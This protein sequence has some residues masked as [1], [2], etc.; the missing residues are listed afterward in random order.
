MTLLWSRTV[1][2]ECVFVRRAADSFVARNRHT[3]ARHWV[4]RTQELCLCAISLWIAGEMIRAGVPYRA[5][6][7]FHRQIAMHRVIACKI[8]SP[9]CA[10]LA[11]R[12]AAERSARWRRIKKYQKVSRLS[13]TLLPALAFRLVLLLRRPAGSGMLSMQS[14][15]KF[16]YLFNEN[17]AQS[18]LASCPFTATENILFEQSNST[19]IP[20]K[21]K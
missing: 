8:L 4:H 17:S 15:R 21:K 6:V 20:N 19:Y 5:S 18:M 16:S 12:S 13:D 7:S 14:R 11:S 2:D 9:L 1:S 10:T 3:L